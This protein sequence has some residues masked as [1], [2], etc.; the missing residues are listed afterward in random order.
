MAWQNGK[1]IDGIFGKD[2]WVF[3]GAA[4]IMYLPFQHLS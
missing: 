1:W 2:G 4:N 3:V